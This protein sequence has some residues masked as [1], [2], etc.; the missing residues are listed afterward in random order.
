MSTVETAIA[1]RVAHV[2]LRRPE[3]ANAVDLPTARALVDAVRAIATDDT[4]GAVLLSGD[5]PRFCAGGD[6]ATMAV[7]EDPEAYLL[8]LAD[9][10]D[11]AL[12]ELA[13][14][15]RPVV[16]AVQGAVAGAGLGVMLSCDVIVSAP[17]TRFVMAYA[18]VGLTPDCGVSWLLPRAIG[19]QRA[20]ELALTGRVLS[21]PEAV[22]WGL[23]TELAD[24]P[25]ERATELARSLAAGPSHAFGQAR[26]L[27]RGAWSASRAAAGSDESRTIAAAVRTADAQRALARFRPE[28][29]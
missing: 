24:Q 23:V 17:T 29:P 27:L 25:L 4:V 2:R 26:R 8:E 28:T 19:Q 15:E 5:G 22:Q 7:A 10:L 13:A 16:C 3:V 9:T 21:G 1:D 18:G 20:L 11:G 14:L 12:Q 6:A